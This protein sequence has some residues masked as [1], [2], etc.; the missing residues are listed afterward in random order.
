VVVLPASLG[1]SR[2]K[3]S[4]GSTEKLIPRSASTSFVPRLSVPLRER[5][6]RR[7]CSTSIAPTALTLEDRR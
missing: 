3:S 2:P 7:N 1:P 5:Y 4:P 6:T